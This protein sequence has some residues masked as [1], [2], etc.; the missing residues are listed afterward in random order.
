MLKFRELL[1]VPNLNYS[2]FA[3][4]MAMPPLYYNVTDVK[5]DFNFA[6]HRPFSAE[7][8]GTMFLSVYHVFAV[9]VMLNLLIALMTTVFNKG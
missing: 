5:N 1:C 9:I 7:W 8:I 3:R 2:E 6:P 4:I